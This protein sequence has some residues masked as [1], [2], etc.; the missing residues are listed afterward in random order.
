M[1]LVDVLQMDLPAKAI[2][3]ELKDATI[4]PRQIRRFRR[5]KIAPDFDIPQE[6]IDKMLATQNQKQLNQKVRDAW[7]VAETKLLDTLHDFNERCEV[8]WECSKEQYLTFLEGHD[9]IIKTLL[10]QRSQAIS[11]A[12]QNGIASIW[13]PKEKEIETLFGKHHHRLV[14]CQESLVKPSERMKK[15]IQRKGEQGCKAA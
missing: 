15:E 3:S 12:K 5:G 10:K 13:N 7:Y 6:S 11:D 8:P 2:A 1:K 14:E 4:T 9:Q